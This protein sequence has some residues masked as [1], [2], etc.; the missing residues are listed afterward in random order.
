MLG[1]LAKL[2]PCVLSTVRKDDL[3][4]WITGA[5]VTARTSDILLAQQNRDVAIAFVSLRDIF[6]AIQKVIITHTTS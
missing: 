5:S 4:L 2:P 6:N 1:S 3:L